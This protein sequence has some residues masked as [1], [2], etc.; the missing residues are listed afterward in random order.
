MIG[1]IARLFARAEPVL[2]EAGPHDAA[3][4]ATLHSASF[5]RGWSETEFERLLTDKS[6]IAHYATGAR[7]HVGFILSRRAAGEA[8]ILSVA[9]AAQYRGRGLG[10]R[11]LDLHLRRLA[12]LGVHTVF[13]EVEQENVAACRLYARAGFTEVARRP[14]YYPTGGGEAAIALVLRREL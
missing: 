13:L 12:G 11:L 2:A 3:V 8:E 4:L 14:G 7:D 1:F 10:R 9:I 5:R 6:V